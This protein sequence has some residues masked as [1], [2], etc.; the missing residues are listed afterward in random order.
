[1]VCQ[2]LSGCSLAPLHILPSSSLH[3]DE[4]PVHSLSTVTIHPFLL[5]ALFTCCVS[6][7]HSNTL[8][9]C[10]FYLL[11]VSRLPTRPLYGPAPFICC[12]SSS[13]SDTL[14]TCPLYLL[15]V[16]RLPSLTLCG[17][18]PRLC[19][20]A[21]FTC[22]VSSPYSDTLW[23]CLLYLLY[24]S[25]L[26]TLTLYGPAS[27]TCCACLVLTLYGPAPDSVDL[28][29][30]CSAVRPPSVQLYTA[31]GDAYLPYLRSPVAG[32]SSMLASLS[33]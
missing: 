17:P 11:Y 14:C 18:C 15:C 13:W 7:S 2:L 3:S 16:S 26:P 6:S 22:C 28:P 8:W 10:P 9:T 20:P 24:V 23:T 12:V 33:K 27:F 1:M 25:R 19:G 32:G 31:R 30:S 29:L 5:S 21:P 4:L